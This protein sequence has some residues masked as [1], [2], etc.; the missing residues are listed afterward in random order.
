MN[1]EMKVLLCAVVKQENNYL[2]EWVEWYKKTGVDKVL[3]YDNNDTDGEDPKDVIGDYVKKRYVSIYNWRGRKLI[4]KA[5]YNDA[6]KRYGKKYDWLMMLDVDEFLKIDRIPFERNVKAWLSQSLFDGWDGVK[7]CWKCM[8]DSG[9][10]RVED[11]NYSRDRFTEVL[12]KDHSDN[13]YAKTIVRGGLDIRWEPSV[14]YPIGLKNCCNVLGGAEKPKNKMSA[15][16]P[17]WTKA[18]LLH[19]RYRTIEEYVTNKMSRLY[20]DHDDEYAKAYLTLERFFA[21]NEWTDEKEKM[22]L[23]LISH[24]PADS[25]K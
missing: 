2:R 7:V 6:Y 1:K 14:H 10:V 17:M 23:S 24:S 21:Y 19:Y 20:A 4:Q 5:A 11:G 13:Y 9:L 25:G 15:R 18:V 16:E 8:T 22:C 12:R 3:I